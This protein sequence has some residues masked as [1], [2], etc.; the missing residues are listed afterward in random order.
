MSGIIFVN[1]NPQRFIVPSTHSE[2]QNFSEKIMKIYP[3][4]KN[5]PKAVLSNM[6]LE[7]FALQIAEG[8]AHLEKL[9]IVHRYTELYTLKKYNFIEWVQYLSLYR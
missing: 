9:Q 3:T 5:T 1:Q 6:E 7:K 2:K 8:M 4:F